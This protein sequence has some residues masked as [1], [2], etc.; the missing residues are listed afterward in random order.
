MSRQVG[1]EN[2]CRIRRLPFPLRTVEHRITKTVFRALTDLHTSAPQGVLRGYFRH[3]EPPDSPRHRLR[4]HQLDRLRL[5]RHPGDA[6][7]QRAGHAAHALGGAPRR[8]GRGDGGRQGAP[9]LRRRPRQ[10]ARRVQA[11][12]G[13]RAE[14]RLPRGEEGAHPR[15]ALG[16]GAQ[17][18]ARRRDRAAR[19]RPA[20][21]GHLGARAVRAAAERG[22]LGGGA[23]GRLRA[24][25]A[26]SGADRLRARRGLDVGDLV[27]RVARLRPRRR[28]LRRLAAR[29]ARRAAARGRPRRRQ[30]PRRA[31]LR[32]RPGRLGAGPGAAADRPARHPAGRAARRRAA[33]AEDGG[34]G[35][36]DR[37]HPRRLGV[38]AAAPRL[39]R[40]RRGGRRRRHPRARA[41]AQAVPAAGGPEHRRLPAAVAHPRARAQ[42][43][44][45]RGAGRRPHRDAVSPRPAARRCWG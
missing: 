33:P 34:G 11:A 10:H 39:H 25:G 32:Q 16:R 24:G 17:V 23:A 35:R 45:Q 26:D 13:H 28:H 18:L 15:A 6:G 9:L 1:C 20:E 2:L 38:G 31:R 21:G 30:L 40:R 4:H 37:A 44:D 14:N 36:Q 19:L 5:R 12:D 27:G 22:H 29:D 3:H 42:P 43:A 8:Q 7:A 41:A